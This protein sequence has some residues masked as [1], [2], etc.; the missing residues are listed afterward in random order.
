MEQA[1]DYRG[2]YFVLHG[3]LSPID[4]IG[5]KELKLDLL[6]KILAEQPVEE[7]IIAT[8]ST[9][10]GETTAQY[11]SQLAESAGITASR[12]AHGVPLGGEIEYIDSNTLAHAFGSRVKI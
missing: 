9:I 2:R 11:L 3:K 1:T 10:E 8:S 7:M 6:V 5:I 12:L 4:G